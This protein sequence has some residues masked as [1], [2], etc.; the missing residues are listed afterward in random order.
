MCKRK[1]NKADECEHMGKD[2]KGRGFIWV[3]MLSTAN[4]KSGLI[5]AWYEFSKQG[6][7]AA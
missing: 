6:N 4:G 1:L 2:I 3:L 5:D 7:E